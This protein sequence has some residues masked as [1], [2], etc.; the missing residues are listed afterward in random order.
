WMERK[1][2][3]EQAQALIAKAGGI[4]ENAAKID[5]RELTEDENREFDQLHNEAGNLL[6]EVQHMER[7]LDA[8]KSFEE[9]IGREPLE[10]PE[11]QPDTKS[12]ERFLRTGQRPEQRTLTKGTANEGAEFVPDSFYDSYVHFLRELDTLIAAGADEIVTSNGQNL[13]IPTFDDTANTGELL[14]E[15]ST[16]TD[17]DDDPATAEIVLGA[18]A[19]SSKV[20]RL[21]VHLT[22]DAGY[23]IETALARALAERLADVQNTYFTTGTGTNQPK[24]VVTCASAGVTGASTTAITYN[25][26]L[27][28]VHACPRPYRSSAKLM[29]SDATFLAIKK[30]VDGNGNPLWNA[31]NIAAGVPG[32]I[33]GFSY[34][35]NP[36]MSDME[37]SAK[38][39]LFGDFSYYKVRRVNGA[40][41]LRFDDSAFMKKLQVGYMLWVRA[42]ANGTNSNAIKY[43]VNAAS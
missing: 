2:K 36:K 29:F 1:A 4:L 5:K 8:E 28:L 16:T 22:Q 19:F 33:D 21:S 15:G 9:R 35:I 27:D 37:A 13:P 30:L 11:P 31:G 18:H 40:E 3:R 23:P 6:A 14:S 17:N 25:E 42:D 10:Q 39:I 26:I 32:T 41:L 43:F 38:S 20:V 34:V 7:Q 12:F 24:G